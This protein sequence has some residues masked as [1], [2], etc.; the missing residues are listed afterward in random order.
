MSKSGK[1]KEQ[2]HKFLGTPSAISRIDIAIPR[3]QN[4]ERKRWNHH[5]LEGGEW[6]GT[7]SP[8]SE[9]FLTELA[10]ADSTSPSNLV[11]SLES[12]PGNQNLEI[13]FDRSPIKGSEDLETGNHRSPRG[14][15]NLEIYFDRPP[16]R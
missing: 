15:Q 1:K 4:C 5:Q 13:D 6:D 9:L 3:Q 14:N 12:K 2:D 7:H 8:G 11:N 10:T 16:K